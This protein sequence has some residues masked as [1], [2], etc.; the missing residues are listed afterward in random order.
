M[1]GVRNQG[2]DFLISLAKKMLPAI[3]ISTLLNEES[4]PVLLEAGVKGFLLRTSGKAELFEAVKRVSKH[5]NFYSMSVMRKLSYAL[6]QELSKLSRQK[7]SNSLSKSELIL[8]DFICKG[9][10]IPEIAVELEANPNSLA[11]KRARLY[12]KLNIHSKSE[13]VAYAIKNGLCKK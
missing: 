5:E 11:V 10:T 9:Y 4:F 6:T 1:A 12:K 2:M 13:M 7:Q 8:I 3:V